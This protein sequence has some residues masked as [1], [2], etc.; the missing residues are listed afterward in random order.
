[1]QIDFGNE[2]NTKRPK[3]K[4]NKGGERLPR[5]FDQT[6]TV[7][8]TYKVKRWQERLRSRKKRRGPFAVRSSKHC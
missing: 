3:D 7:S 4:I 6:R 5:G 2:L 8:N 1:M